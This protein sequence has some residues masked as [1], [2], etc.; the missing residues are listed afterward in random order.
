MKE[1][2]WKDGTLCKFF[3]FFAVSQ[4]GSKFVGSWAPGL[5]LDELGDAEGNE[6]PLSPAK[7]TRVLN[8]CFV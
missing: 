8:V 4:G 5:L 3:V 7:K 2:P 1:N 6:V